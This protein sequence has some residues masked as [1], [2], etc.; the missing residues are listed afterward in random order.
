MQILSR[1]EAWAAL[2]AT[3]V[4]GVKSCGQVDPCETLF[5]EDF[6]PVFEEMMENALA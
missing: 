6:K 2:K 3:N 1:D 5:T 4:P